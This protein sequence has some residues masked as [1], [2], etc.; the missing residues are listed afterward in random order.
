VAVCTAKLSEAR[1]LVESGVRGSLITSP[2]VTASKI[3][4][5][6]SL[7]RTDAQL[8]VTVDSERN[9]V[10]LQSAAAAADVRLNC[11]LELEVGQKRTGVLRAGALSLAR[12]LHTQS[13]THFAGVQAYCGHL[14]H[15][16]SYAE[17]TRLS[18]STMRD[19]AEFVVALRAAGLDVPIFTG[20]QTLLSHSVDAAC[21]LWTPR[22]VTCA[23]IQNCT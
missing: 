11:V 2:Q 21:V 7:T 19:A 18:V 4:Q 14:Q 12:L 5:L 16:R 8:M 13:H 23:H 17:R 20:R 10:Q 3:A 1:I 22:S 6:L 15:V 9:A